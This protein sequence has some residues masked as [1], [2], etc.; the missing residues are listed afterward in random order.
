ME[1]FRIDGRFTNGVLAPMAGLMLMLASGLSD[2]ARAEVYEFVDPNG[3]IHFSNVPTDPRYYRLPSNTPAVRLSP[4]KIQEVILRASRRYR[5]EPALIQAVIK[6][7]SD[8]N[9]LAVSSAGAMGL[10]QLMPATAKDLGVSNP[11]NPSENIMGGVRH[12]SDLLEYFEGDLTMSLAAYH[13]GARRVEQFGHV[14]PIDQTHRYV[15]KVLTAYQAYRGP[16]LPAKPTFRV[17]TNDGADIYTNVPE[18]YLDT[19]RYR[20]AY[21]R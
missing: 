12:L 19:R 15:W 6:V 4:D 14:P 21:V 17:R 7:E 10:M 9:P 3:V 11:F 8:F 1:T 20:I 5:L 2:S 13:A 18:Q 16:N